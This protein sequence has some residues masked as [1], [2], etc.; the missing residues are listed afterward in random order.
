MES[1]KNISLT[2]QGIKLLQGPP[3]TGK[4]HTLLGIVSGIYH[5][6]KTS[7]ST[8][9]RHIL[10]CAP[11]NCAIDEIITRLL[12]KGLYNEKAEKFIPKVVRLGVTT[13]TTSS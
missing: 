13:Q 2:K 1:I 6:M 9:K 10:V 12:S 4:T 3:G 5:Y 7:E 8:H 11:S